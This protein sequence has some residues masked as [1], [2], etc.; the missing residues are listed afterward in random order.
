MSVRHPL[1]GAGA[2]STSD[3]AV[4]YTSPE[5]YDFNYHAIH[6]NDTQDVDVDVTLDGTNWISS[7]P[8]V[9]T[10]GAALAT[11][12]IPAGSVGI[13]RGKFAKIRV[14]NKGGTTSADCIV[15]HAC[16]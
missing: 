2:A 4:L 15:L 5:V 9:D 8:L 16:E 10:A 1:T 6:S 13:I 7:V 3:D 11:N 12:E 14:L